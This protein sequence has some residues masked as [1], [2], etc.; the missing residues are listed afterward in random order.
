[1]IRVTY[2]AVI[3]CHT[4]VFVFAQF[5]FP[6]YYW[7]SVRVANHGAVFP[8]WSSHHEISPENRQCEWQWSIPPS[9]S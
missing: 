1:M 9:A 4:R 2:G 8:P 3:G 7:I 6:G 5:E